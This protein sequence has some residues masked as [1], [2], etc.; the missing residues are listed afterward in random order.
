MQS[1]W[2]LCIANNCYW[3]WEITPLSNL[4]GASLVVEWK[5][6]SEKR[7]ELRLR[8]NVGNVKRQGKC[9]L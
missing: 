9:L 1:H 6:Y 3:F 7:I 5:T 4:N 2:L 8:E